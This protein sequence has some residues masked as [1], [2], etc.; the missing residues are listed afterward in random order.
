MR[1]CLRGQSQQEWVEFFIS[2]SVGGTGGL[3]RTTG[4]RAPQIRMREKDNMSP[5]FA[6]MFS[7][8]GNHRPPNEGLEEG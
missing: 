1:T 2:E 8:S 7:C 4:R 5:T 6:A 3:R